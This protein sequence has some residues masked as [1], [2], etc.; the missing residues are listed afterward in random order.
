LRAACFA[1][2]EFGLLTQL[3]NTY[4]ENQHIKETDTSSELQYS[5]RKTLFSTK[6][7]GD[8]MPKVEPL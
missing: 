6:T 1:P 8:A 3:S 7:A 5:E 2:S 4:N